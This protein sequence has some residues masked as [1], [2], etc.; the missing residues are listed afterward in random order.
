MV[1]L[2]TIIALA[3]MTCIVSLNAYELYP[4]DE[5]IFNEIIIECYSFTL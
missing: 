3:S 5:N 1:E 4:K 2:E